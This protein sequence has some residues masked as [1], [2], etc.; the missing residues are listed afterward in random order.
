MFLPLLY[1]SARA[2]YIAP[3]YIAKQQWQKFRF[4]VERI[5]VPFP[6]AVVPVQVADVQ[7]AVVIAVSRDSAS[8]NTASRPPRPARRQADSGL[9]SKLYRIRDLKS[10]SASRRVS[11]WYGLACTSP[12]RT[13]IR[14]APCASRS[15]AA[16]GSRNRPRI[17]FACYNSTRKF[18]EKE[19]GASHGRS[20]KAP[21][22]RGAEGLRAKDQ[23]AK[24]R[25][26]APSPK[27]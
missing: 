12:D 9:L 23:R 11:S 1:Y 13:L 3:Q 21:E 5:V 27:C 24:V 25:P 17:R 8:Q 15:G 16:A 7:V 14:T 10:P 4:W 18:V 22:V 19:E 20:C 26:K 6:L 2:R